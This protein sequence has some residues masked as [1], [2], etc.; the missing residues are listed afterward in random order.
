MIDPTIGRKV[1]YWPNGAEET[2]VYRDD[3][4]L[5]AS[6]CFVHEATDDWRR[7]NVSVI[8]HAGTLHG[9]QHVALV[10]EGEPKPDAGTPY[11]EWMP[12]QRGQ[13]KRRDPMNQDPGGIGA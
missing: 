11:C 4:A 10:Q 1:W 6:V 5:D 8:D 2:T 3:Q 12:F 7:I 9:R 13:A